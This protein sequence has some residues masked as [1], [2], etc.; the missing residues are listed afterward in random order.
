M[1]LKVRPLDPV[2][3]LALVRAFVPRVADYVL[4]ETGEAPKTDLAEAFFAET[5]PGGTVD[6]LVHLGLFDAGDLAGVAAMS[7]GYPE[8]GDAYLGLL[9]ID[10]ARRGRGLGPAL[11]TEVLGV[12]RSQAAARLYLGVLEAN[13]RARAFWERAGFRHVL[14]KPRV[15][16]GARHH[17]V[18][19]MMRPV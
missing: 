15:A 11:L 13:P 4:L 5:P 9:L 18:H 3:D 2:D 10:A 8:A 1:A 6:D 17:D 14:T 7:F 19:R 12:A 16:F